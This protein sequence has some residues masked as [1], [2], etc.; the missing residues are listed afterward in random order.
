M[1]LAQR[2]APGPSILELAGRLDE[3]DDELVITVTTPQPADPRVGQEVTA[4]SAPEL[5]APSAR[6]N[7]VV[8]PP[9][10][11]WSAPPSPIIPTGP[12]DST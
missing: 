12:S 2:V 8:T 10:Y 9:A 6:A 3:A 4:G 11:T 5:V 7:V 1:R